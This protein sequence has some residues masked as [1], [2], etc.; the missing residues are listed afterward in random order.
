MQHSV[1]MNGGTNRAGGPRS[2]MRPVLLGFLLTVLLQVAAASPAGAG[3]GGDTARI[4]G[5][6]LASSTNRPVP[7]ATVLLP[8]Y[9]IGATSGPD[10]SFEF[11]NPLATENP[12]RRI[13]AVVTAPGWGRWTI[14]GV[15]LYPNDTLRLHV[16]LRKQDWDHRVLTPEERLATPKP[17]VPDSTYTYTCT[18][19]NY[20]LVPPETIKVWITADQVSEQYDFVFYATHVLPNEWIPSWDADSLGAGAIPVKTYAAYRAMPGHAYSEGDGCADIVDSTADQVFDPTW[21]TAATDQ[22]VYATL[23]SVLYKSGRLFLSQY[24]AGAPDDPCAPVEGQYAGRMSQWGTQTCA[25]ESVLW[26]DIVT[27]FYENGTS[28]HYLNN[29]ILDPKVESAGTYPWTWT[30]TTTRTKG[31][32]YDG[33]WYWLLVPPPGVNGAI[34]ER[35]PFDGTE[36]TTYHAEVALRCGTENSASCIITI[37]VVTIEAGGKQHIK[38]MTVTEAN[39][40]V[41]RL[42]TYDPAASGYDHAE[43]KLSIVSRSTIGVDGAV[44]TS[45]Y[46]GP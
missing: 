24:Y 33:N 38:K 14:R 6:V 31:G 41:W 34:R 17:Q 18:G 13:R 7:G 22:A 43:V 46:G 3:P 2:T 25:L 42:Y 23:G 12:Y 11:P 29:L 15:P 39:D 4:E 1:L 35:Q 40:S 10:G 21:S 37:S 5:Q 9:G 32:S 28:W 26:P 19:W 30:G 45:D 20:Q 36:S 44:L 16:E 27:T 8:D